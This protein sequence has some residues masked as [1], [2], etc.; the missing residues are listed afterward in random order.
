MPSVLATIRDTTDNAALR[1]R[2]GTEVDVVDP[3]TLKTAI[4]RCRERGVILPTFDQLEDPSRIPAGIRRRLPAV[5]PDAPE[6]LN[7]FRVHWFNG[8]DRASAAEVPAHVV[9]PKCITGVESPIVVMLG[10]GFPMIAAHKVLA[11]Y[12]CLAP[13]LVTGQFDPTQHRAVWPSTGN[14]CRGGIAVS[15]I[16]GC[17]GVAVLPENMSQ[18]RFDWLRNWVEN[19][20]DI[21]RTRGSESNVKEIYDACALL[22][23]DP[24]NVIL[25]QFCEFGNALAHYQVTG[26]A[27]GRLFE[28]L[29]VG[30]TIRTLHSFVSATG[31][32][33]TLSAGDRLKEDFGTRIVAVEAAEC[34]TLL[35]NGFGEHHIQGIG[36]KHV[37]Y[38]HNVF[39]TD[40][41]VAVSDA[42]TDQLF[43]LAGQEEGRKYLVDRRGVSPDLVAA[44][45]HIG[46]SGWANIVGAIRIA[47]AHGLDETQS[48]FTVATDGAP[49]YESERPRIL[50]DR[51]GGVFDLIAAAECFSRFVLGAAASEHV[52][53]RRE[54]RER[55]FNLGYFTWVEQLGVPVDSFLARRRQSFWRD[56][57]ASTAAWDARIREFNGLTGVKPA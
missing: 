56:L 36:D 33:G 39:A 49:L 8:P 17:R 3:E 15:R 53:M 47:V 45:V 50:R 35:R 10:D 31:S 28:H 52:E 22:E 46:P 19:P 30:S 5:S 38:I 23:Q 42:A 4:R 13:R 21:I 20:A 41:I 57:R 44:L 48:V 37:P 51:F 6:S 9:L 27:F 40:D 26:R 29:Q 18:E 55:V 14:Y 24:R 2:F 12:G 25:N 54:D 32:A 7:L 1:R 11:A 43:Y 16:M 34:P